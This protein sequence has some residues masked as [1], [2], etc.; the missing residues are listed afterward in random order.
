MTETP[1]VPADLLR[2]AL[3]GDPQC[4]PDGRVFFVLST[5]DE[6]S[7]ETR[8][9]IWSVRAGSPAT[10]FTSGLHDRMPRISPD[11]TQLAFIG[12]R[13]EATC[14]YVMPLGGGEARAVTPD[15]E[16]LGGL[17]WAPGS[18]AVAYVAKTGLDASGARSALDE[19]SGARHIRALPFKS[20]EEGLLDGRRKHLFVCRPE[21]GAPAV[22]LTFG[23]FDVDSPA[24]S[25]DGASLAF[26]AQ[27]DVPETAFWSD[28]FVVELGGGE[29]RKLTA[30]QGPAETPAFSRD[31]REIA[32]VG[33]LHGEA[34]TP[35]NLELLVVPSAGGAIR[36]LSAQLDRSIVDSI[37]CDVRGLAPPQPPIWSAGDREIFVPLCS[38]AT[39]GIAA[40]ARDGSHHRVVAGGERDIFAFARS[41][42]GTLAFAFST[43]LV[44]S[45]IAQLDPYGNESRLTDCNPW[46]AQRALRAPRRLRP[47]AADGWVLDL[48]LLDPDGAGLAPYVLAV[49][50]GPHTAYG[51]AFSFEF[52]TIVSHG[53][54]VAYGNPRG[55]TSYGFTFADGVT[56]RWGQDDASDVL[57]LLD[58]T[59]AAAPADPKRIA[60]AGGSYGGFM[61]TW[62]LG[63]SKRFATGISMRAV[64]DFVSEVGAADLGWFLERTLG[65]PWDDGGRK[66]FENSP[67]RTAH[68]IDVPLLI[69]HSERDYR[70]PIDQ[71]EQLFTLLRR[72]GRSE[73]EFVRFSGDGHGLSRSGHPRNRILRLRAI[74]HWLARHLKPDGPLVAPLRE[75]GALFKELATEP[76]APAT[77]GAP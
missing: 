12:Q 14:V 65:A 5:Q 55:S 18:D 75:A 52:Q 32:F 71:G 69:M 47:A 7:D 36:S 41:D 24:W 15:C 72:L 57:S 42:D 33:H 63:H 34:F 9:A 23:D 39:C 70:C 8:S 68:Q 19:R 11:A 50:G 29:L 44:A 25:P 28:V 61:T 64:N 53:I 74:V 3:P 4:A 73:T 49:H 54:G 2:L 48:F 58:A 67:M 17:V 10:P 38:E 21:P 51:F 46:L 37:I 1:L 35:H 27:I 22:Q 62:L 26:T 56:G 31:G 40:F 30:G 43:P 6:A 76:V 60:L 20:D 13:A 77:P 59:L 45:E 66:L 16:A